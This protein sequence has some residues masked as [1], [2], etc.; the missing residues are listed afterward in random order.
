VRFH[1]VTMAQVPKALADKPSLDLGVLHG[2]DG[3]RTETVLA[4]CSA[5]GERERQSV[6][7]L[8]TVFDASL[9]SCAEAMAREQA[10]IDAA[11]QKSARSEREIV[12]VELERLYLPLPVHLKRRGAT[13]AGRDAGT[14]A[15]GAASDYA[16]PAKGEHVADTKVRVR[17]SPG[18]PGPPGAAPDND[19]G[20][21][22]VDKEAEKENV[23]DDEDEKELR[24]MARTMGTDAKPPPA[25]PVFGS[26]TYL[27][28]NYAILYVAIIAFVVLLFG[29]R[30]RQDR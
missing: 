10:A 11:R 21:V 3:S 17:R 25:V 19:D 27:Q 28:P 24:K 4:E 9:P 20:F 2:S 5:N 30:R 29:Q 23:D 8:W 18:A 15:P 14:Q 1:Y 12:Q 22:W 7:E 13:A 16:A 26:S 6:G